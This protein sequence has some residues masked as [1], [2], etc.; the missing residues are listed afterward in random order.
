MRGA[1]SEFGRHPSSLKQSVIIVDFFD[2]H[3]Q[4]ELT[5]VDD[6]GCF[7]AMEFR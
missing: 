4:L 6:R 5:H 3:Q 2:R 7:G 1:R